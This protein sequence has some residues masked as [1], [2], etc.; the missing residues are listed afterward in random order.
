MHDRPRED[1]DVDDIREAA[2]DAQHQAEVLVD[3]AI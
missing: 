1:G 2:E 3:G